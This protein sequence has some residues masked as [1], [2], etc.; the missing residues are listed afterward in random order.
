MFYLTCSWNVLEAIHTNKKYNLIEEVY[1]MT[2]EKKH[3][4]FRIPNI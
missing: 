1:A 4:Y 2:L 3:S